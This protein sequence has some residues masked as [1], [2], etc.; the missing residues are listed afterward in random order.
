MAKLIG[1]E[2]LNQSPG[3]APGR[4]KICWRPECAEMTSISIGGVSGAGPV[5]RHST[6]FSI[7]C[8]TAT[9]W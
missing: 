9:R 8:R 7:H 5:G 2:G 3:R 6:K 1:Y 4:S